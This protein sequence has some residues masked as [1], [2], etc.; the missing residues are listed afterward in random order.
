MRTTSEVEPG[1]ES[2]LSNIFRETRR[3]GTR[4][5]KRL[6]LLKSLHAPRLACRVRRGAW[7]Q[8]KHRKRARLDGSWHEILAFNRSSISTLS[9]KYRTLQRT[10]LETIVLAFLVSD[11]AVPPQLQEQPNMTVPLP[12]ALLAR[13]SP[14]VGSDPKALASTQAQSCH[15]RPGDALYH[16]SSVQTFQATEKTLYGS[17]C[18]WT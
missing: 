2:K 17:L 8:P 5:V 7:K 6:I 18:P 4:A 15:L 9:D 12:R 11:T 13:K 16:S 10:R 1:T 3:R 14:L